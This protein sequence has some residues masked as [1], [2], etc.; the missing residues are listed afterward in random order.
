MGSLASLALSPRRP[1]IPTKMVKVAATAR[2]SSALPDSAAG[3]NAPAGLRYRTTKLDEPL[4]HNP[5][6]QAVAKLRECHNPD[7]P[8][9]RLR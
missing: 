7:L 5:L 2:G 9:C 4:R 8:S 1:A 6:F 3:R